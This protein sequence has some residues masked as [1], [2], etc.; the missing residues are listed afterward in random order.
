VRAR[1]AVALLLGVAAGGARAQ[2]MLDQE[3]RLVEIH[4][5]L[6]FLP[7]LEAPAA[8]RPLQARVG[9]ELVGIP[10]IDGTTGSKV[11]ITASD[12]ARVFP[13][14]RLGLGLPVGGDWSAV[15]GAAWIPPIEVNQVTVDMIGLEAGLAWSPGPFA[16]GLR[17][18]GEYADSQS[19]VTDPST[20]DR[21]ITRIAG[22]DLSAAWR[23]RPGSIELTPYASVGVARVEGTFT[24]T[25]DGY[26]L[27]STTTNLE[28]SA[29][30]R[31]LAF[32]QLEV[33]AELVAFPGV[34]IHPSFTISWVPGLAK[35]PPAP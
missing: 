32:R 1:L 16:A 14:L 18:H 26:Q 23:F 4:S 5:L 15:A 3:E 28:L 25:S 7:A 29:G 9:L 24:V 11:Q 8:L 6:F 13:R 12:K 20:R 35:A 31:L 22:A 2:T 10:V 33:A 17:L 30:L 19:P 34:L 27:G 21:L